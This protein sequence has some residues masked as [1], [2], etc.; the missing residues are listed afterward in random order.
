M[1]VKQMWAAG[2]RYILV[3]VIALIAGAALVFLLGGGS[4]SAKLAETKRSLADAQSVNRL[5]TASNLKLQQ[6]LDSATQRATE[7]QQ[8]IAGL[9]AQAASEQSGLD[10]IAA[11]VTSAGGDLYSRALAIASGFDKLYEVYHGG[12]TA[13]GGP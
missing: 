9:R 13:S 12:A 6:Q 7:N 4:L 3:A 10:A 11:S 1:N 2:R 8:L 5:V